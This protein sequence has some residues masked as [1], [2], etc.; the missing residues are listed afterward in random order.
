MRPCLIQRHDQWC[1]RI[2]HRYLDWCKTSSFILNSSGDSFLPFGLRWSSFPS[3]SSKF[4]VVPISF[5]RCSTNL[6]LFSFLYK[7][8]FFINEKNIHGNDN[9]NNK[10][11]WK[12]FWCTFKIACI[13]LSE[14]ITCSIW[15][16]FQSR[17]YSLFNYGTLSFR[18]TFTSS[19]PHPHSQE[20]QNLMTFFV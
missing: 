6:V 8:L 10:R 4:R 17:K 19:H 3:F 13:Y 15:C 5:W 20:E 7:M 16:I 1:M 12:F 2:N 11:E 14:N 9:N 18:P